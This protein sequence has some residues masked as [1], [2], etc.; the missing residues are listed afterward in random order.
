[1]DTN[2]GSINLT[3]RQIENLSS[4]KTENIRGFAYW[5]D[6]K[7]LVVT[8]IN[9]VDVEALKL[10]IASLPDEDSQEEKDKLAE[11]ELNRL[12]DAKKT[13]LAIQALKDDGL[14]DSE[15]K[16][17]ESGKASLGAIK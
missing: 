5:H 17:T 8:S 4:L 15:A 12:I 6:S 16:I 7:E 14:L 13:E 2:L 3:E 1:M 11:E 9:P 10:A